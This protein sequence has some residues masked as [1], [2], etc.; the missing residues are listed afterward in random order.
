VAGAFAANLGLQ[1][2]SGAA[3]AAAGARRAL[4]VGL[5]AGNC[6]MAVVLAALPQDTHP[7]TLLWFALA[8]FPIYTLPALLSRPYRRVLG[9]TPAPS[10]TGRRDRSRSA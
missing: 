1:A 5:A 7:D 3:F 10:R 6:N 8:Q 2:V 9:V 4:T